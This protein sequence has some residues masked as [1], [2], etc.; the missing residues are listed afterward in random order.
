MTYVQL[1]HLFTCVRIWSAWGF[2]PL[3]FHQE[4]AQMTFSLTPTKSKLK[5]WFCY[6]LFGFNLAYFIFHLATFIEAVRS[7]L[8]KSD[9]TEFVLGL[10][11]L[12]ARQCAIFPVGSTGVV[13]STEQ[14]TIVSRHTRMNCNLG[15][16]KRIRRIILSLQILLNRVKSMIGSFLQEFGLITRRGPNRRGLWRLFKLHLSAVVQSAEECSAASLL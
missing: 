4:L 15:K 5:K 2:T 11:F 8:Y 10:A 16:S 3:D 12:V 7:K 6:F 13:K 1:R 14:A 9:S